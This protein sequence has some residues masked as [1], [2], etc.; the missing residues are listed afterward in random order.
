MSKTGSSILRKILMA[1]SGMF[2]MFF[3]LQHFTINLTSVFS[4]DIFNAFSHF[5]GTNFL[6]QFILQPV[7]IFGVIFHFVMG[8]ILEIQNRKSRKSRYAYFK[9]SENST[10]ISR[11]MIVSGLVV[12]SFLT[13]HFYDFWVP[14]IKYKYVNFLPEDPNRYYEE[15]I[16]KFDSPTR[17]VLYVVSFFFLSLHLLHGFSS[18]FQS[19]G[20]DRKYSKQIKVFGKIFAIFVPLGFAFIAV[21]HHLTHL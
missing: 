15:L 13:L 11:N 10:W 8:F 9:G 16:H 2:L 12:L 1:L 3:L 7:L 20:T 14:E 17:V 5:M 6:V 19:M 21:F 4:E 18:S